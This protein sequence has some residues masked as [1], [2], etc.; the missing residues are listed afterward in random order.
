LSG[1]VQ[2]PSSGVGFLPRQRSANDS[3]T[4]Q[5]KQTLEHRTAT[6]S[7]GQRFGQRIETTIVH[8][9]ALRELND[10]DDVLVVIETRPDRRTRRTAS[11]PRE[12]PAGSKRSERAGALVALLKQTLRIL[13][14]RKIPVKHSST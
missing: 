1:Q 12:D 9:Y 3:R 14:F 11:M 13:E 5:A 4:T 10:S 6:F 2:I 7:R 8:E